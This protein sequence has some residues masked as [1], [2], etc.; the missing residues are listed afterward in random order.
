MDGSVLNDDCDSER[1]LPVWNNLTS[2]R[3]PE[4]VPP[5]TTPIQGLRIL[6]GTERTRLFGLLMMM[7]RPSRSVHSHNGLVVP[8]S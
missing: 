7:T 1:P 3:D 8:N 2:Q 5:T 4:L 6:T